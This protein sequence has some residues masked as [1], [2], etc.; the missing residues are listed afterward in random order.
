MDDKQI[1]DLYWAR[2]ENAISKTA[3]KYDKY[4]Y[5]IAFH[6][7]YNKEDS[8][9]CV[10][11]TYLK[12]WDVM[13]PQRPDRLSAFLGKITHNLSLDRYRQYTAKKRGYGQTALVLDELEECVPTADNV[14]NVVD[15]LALGE[16]LNRFLGSLSTETRKVFM[17]RYWYLCFIKEIAADFR[18]SE[19]KVKMTL[20]RSRNELKTLLEKEGIVL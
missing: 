9:E 20:L 10:N 3:E 4:C 15:D 16:I 5:Y 11:D 17:Q 7:L 14:E 6:I 1:I 18:L 8:E 12:A 2:S 13:P 19:S